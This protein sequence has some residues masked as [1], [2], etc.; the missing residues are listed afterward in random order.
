MKTTITLQLKR[1][2]YEM[3]DSGQK[4]EEYRRVTPYWMS[5]ILGC[6][7]GKVCSEQSLSGEVFCPVCLR[8]AW[9]KFDKVIF[10]LGYPRKDEV[11][12]RMVFELDNLMM[13]GGNP[14][15]G[16]EEGRTYFVFKLGKRIS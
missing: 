13:R 4:R 8:M 5:R 14:E 1:K 16:A 15:W 12:K 7:G 3:I 9:K 11:A 6:G 2:W 10:T